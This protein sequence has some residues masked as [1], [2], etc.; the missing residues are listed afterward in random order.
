M[1]CAVT[2]LLV[3]AFQ[4]ASSWADAEARLSLSSLLAMSVGACAI[5]FVCL[6]SMRRQA[7]IERSYRSTVEQLRAMA[8]SVPGALFQWFMTGDE[9]QGFRYISPR[10]K[11]LFGVEVDAVMDDWR[12]L[13][14]HPGDVTRWAESLRRCRASLEDWFFEG[15]FVLSSGDVKWWRGVAKPV[16][17]GDDEVVFNGIILDISDAK[18]AAREIRESRRNAE[19]LG[20]EI[21]LVNQSLNENNETLKRLNH[22]KNEILGIAAHDLKNPLGGVVGFAGAIRLILDEDE[23]ESMRADMVDMTESIEQSARHMLNIINGLLNAAAL[24]DGDARLVMSPCDVTAIIQSVESMNESAARRKNISVNVESEPGCVVHGDPQRLRELVDN[25][26]SNAIK[27]SS[28][29]KS[30]WMQVFHSS[31]SSVQISVRD[32]GPGLT[33]DDKKRIFG[34]FQKLS[35]RPTGGETS[36][37]LGLSIAKSIVELH[38]GRIWAESEFGHGSTFIIDLPVKPARVE[39][40]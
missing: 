10:A 18:E 1:I 29:G 37:G 21:L 31:P 8:D 30:I 2:M 40:E 16:R 27:Y 25:I 36:T 20:V 9:V 15:R 11:E 23:L 38:G 12:K 14:I 32:E 6:V 5:A 22:Q 19:R 7:G 24:E 17:K 28:P 3:G 34:K 39:A 26:L 13:N 33:D 35:A 4:G